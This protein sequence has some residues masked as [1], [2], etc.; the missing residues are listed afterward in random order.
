MSGIP[1]MVWLSRIH[2]ITTIGRRLEYIDHKIG[3]SYDG[4]DHRCGRKE[5]GQCWKPGTAGSNDYATM[6]QIS[7]GD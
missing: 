4:E 3:E 5:S 1:G 7:V 2:E 6:N